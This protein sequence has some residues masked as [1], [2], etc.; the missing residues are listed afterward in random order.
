[1]DLSYCA[2]K[3]GSH[4]QGPE[5]APKLGPSFAIFLCKIC[6]KSKQGLVPGR[7]VFG[8]GLGCLNSLLDAA[9]MGLHRR[10]LQ[11][12]CPSNLLHVASIRD[13]HRSQTVEDHCDGNT[14]GPV[15]GPGCGPRSGPLKIAYF[16]KLTAFLI[17]CAGKQVLSRL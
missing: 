14:S 3:Q 13:Q 16:S 5:M 12:C 9:C 15:L 7:W 1:M 11:F 17:D 6:T 10:S 4:F 2:L 8:S